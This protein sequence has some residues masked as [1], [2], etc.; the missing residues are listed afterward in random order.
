VVIGLVISSVVVAGAVA[1]GYAAPGLPA[2]IYLL[3][4]M[5]AL[6]NGVIPGSI[7][8]FAT[9]A[10]RHPWLAMPW[11]AAGALSGV[12]V[13]G[14]TAFIEPHEGGPGTDI[15]MIVEPYFGLA[16][17]AVGYEVVG[18]LRG[19]GVGAARTRDAS[20]SG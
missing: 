18:R 14:L 16:L 17:A 19:R 6:V 10:R 4:V 7:A 13:F 20:P 12:A 11:F 15:R 9:R 8:I 1:S 2:F 5:G 3:V